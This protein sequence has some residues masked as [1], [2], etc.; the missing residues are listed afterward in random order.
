M[1]AGGRISKG[2]FSDDLKHPTILPNRHTVTHLI[3]LD[4][5]VSKSPGSTETT[6]GELRTSYWVPRPRQAIK[7]AWK[8][9]RFRRR[10]RCRPQPPLMGALPYERLAPLQRPF[11]WVGIDYFGPLFVTVGRST[12][13]RW[14]LLITSLTTRAIHLEVSWSLDTAS[15]LCFFDRFINARGKLTP[16]HFLLVG[17][18]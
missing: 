14:G 16:F 3:I 17:R 18:S 11:L 1:R 13:K 12:A 4:I 5:H 7:R 10:H 2:P 15:F 8:D 6:L 9:C